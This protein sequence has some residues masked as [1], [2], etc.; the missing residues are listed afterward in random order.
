MIIFPF[1]YILL[2]TLQ[3]MVTIW[4]RIQANWEEL[5][6]KFEWETAADLGRFKYVL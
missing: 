6:R 5:I 4:T 1:D 2:V 3:H